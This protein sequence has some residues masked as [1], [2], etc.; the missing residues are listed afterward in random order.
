MKQVV[1]ASAEVSPIA[2]FFNEYG[3]YLLKFICL[4]AFTAYGLIDSVPCALGL[5]T[6]SNFK[7]DSAASL[8][9]GIS[10]CW[11]FIGTAISLWLMAKEIHASP[12]PQLAP[13]TL[14]PLKW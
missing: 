2:A 3:M 11:P 7:G 1:S 6:D 9:I 13:I 14:E 4:V 8:R 12:P 5:L 10:G